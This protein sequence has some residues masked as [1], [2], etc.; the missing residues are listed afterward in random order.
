MKIYRGP[1][2]KNF[3]DDTHQK[4]AE[5]DLSGEVDPWLEYKTIKA[6]ITKD[7]YERKAVTHIQL[8]EDDIL[9]L[10]RGLIDGLKQHAKL[11]KS[12]QAREEALRSALADIQ[13]YAL[14]ASHIGEAEAVAKIKAR[15]E[16]AL[17]PPK[18]L[19]VRRTQ[20]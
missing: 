6:N 13:R 20:R 8:G 14:L 1:S 19:L 3:A 2:Q 15:A 12:T 4:V 7:G 9:A 17:A 11:Y 5:V 18:K 16:Q 10:H